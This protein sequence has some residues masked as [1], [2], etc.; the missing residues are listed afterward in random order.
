MAILAASELSVYLLILILVILCPFVSSNGLGN[1]SGLPFPFPT[2]SVPPSSL[3]EFPATGFPFPLPSDIQPSESGSFFPDESWNPAD[4]SIPSDFIDFLEGITLS[5]YDEE[6]YSCCGE[7]IPTG[8]ASMEF[9]VVLNISGLL[10][11]LKDERAVSLSSGLD[12]AL[13]SIEFW[14]EG[15]D[16]ILQALLELDMGDMKFDRDHSK[17]DD[18]GIHNLE[19][20]FADDVMDGANLPPAVGGSGWALLFDGESDIVRAHVTNFTTEEI[21]VTYWIRATEISPVHVMLEY[22]GLEAGH[23]GEFCLYS[24][25]LLDVWVMDGSVT[26]GVEENNAAFVGIPGEWMHVAV[27]YS[28]PMSHVK[29]WVNGAVVNDHDVDANDTLS[30]EGFF[31]L[32]GEMDQPGDEFEVA[33]QFA[34]MFDE[35]MVFPAVL[36]DDEV[37]DIYATSRSPDRVLPIVDFRFD[38]EGGHGNVSVDSENNVMGELIGVSVEDLRLS[39]FSNEGYRMA[40]WSISGAIEG[41]G[42]TWVPSTIP[43]A[44]RGPLVST[45]MRSRR[46]SPITLIA[47]DPENGT[48]VY[49]IDSLPSQGILYQTDDGEMPSEAITTEGTA[50]RNSNGTVLYAPG[51]TAFNG[52]PGSMTEWAMHTDI[53]P[54]IDQFRYCATD[55]GGLSSCAESF[56][57]ENHAPFANDRK[58]Y[59]GEDSDV[60][61]RIPCYDQ[62]GDRSRAVF[63][64]FPQQG[65]LYNLDQDVYVFPQEE[66]PV[67][68]AVRVYPQLSAVLYDL[69]LSEY[70]GDRITPFFPEVNTEAKHVIFAPGIE[71]AGVGYANM[72]YVCVDEFGQ[73]SNEGTLSIDVSVV[74]DAPI[75]IGQQLHMCED[76]LLTI[77]L[78]AYDPDS[79]YLQYLV[80]S[81]PAAGTM[82]SADNETISKQFSE[83]KVY[84]YVNSGVRSLSTSNVLVGIEGE[85][86]CYPLYGACPSSLPAGYGYV[87]LTFGVPVFPLGIRIFESYQPGSVTRIDFLPMKALLEAFS[88]LGIELQAL[89]D[90][91]YDLVAALDGKEVADVIAE[92]VAGDWVTVYEGRTMPEDPNQVRV[93]APEFCP[94]N[95]STAVVRLK[96]EKDPDLGLTYPYIDA[97]ELLG[98]LQM[99]SN[100][101]RDAVV[102]YRPDINDNGS[103]LA[104][105][106]VSDCISA[107]DHDGI[108]AITICPVNDAPT[109]PAFSVVHFEMRIGQRQFVVAPLRRDDVDSED[110]GLFITASPPEFLPIYD[111]T[112]TAFVTVEYVASLDDAADLPNRVHIG[113]PFNITGS[114]ANLTIP[115]DFYC[116]V[117]KYPL[118]YSAFDGELWSTEGVLEIHCDN[119][120]SVQDTCLSGT[121]YETAADACVPCPAGSYTMTSGQTSCLL[122]DLG[123]YAPEPGHSK[124]MKCN[125]TSYAEE[126]GMTACNSCPRGTAR[127]SGDIGDSVEDCDCSV[128]YYRPPSNPEGTECYECPTGAICEGSS[129][130]PY[131]EDGFWGDPDFPYEFLECQPQS[132][133]KSNFECLTGR[134]GTLC[135]HCVDG[136]FSVGGRCAVCPENSFLR[137]WMTI[138]GI[139]AVILVWCLINTVA[140]FEYDSVDLL[141]LYLQAMAIISQ[142]GLRW[143]EYLEPLLQLVSVVNFDVDFFSPQCLIPWNYGSRIAIQLSVPFLVL[144]GL[145]IRDYMRAS[146]TLRRVLRGGRAMAWH[147]AVRGNVFPSD[148]TIGTMVSV[149]DV[150]YHTLTIKSL[151]PMFCRQMPDGS[152][153]LWAGPSVICGSGVHLVLV[154]MG[155]LGILLYAIGIPVLFSYIFYFGYKHDMLAEP[156]FQKRYGFLFTRYEANYFWWH[157]MLIVRKLLLCI[158][159]VCLSDSPVLQGG[160]ALFVLLAGL[161]GQAYSRPFVQTQLDYL[162]TMLVTTL[163]VFTYCGIM[164]YEGFHKEKVVV[165]LFV[166]LTVSLL[167]TLTVISWE[168]IGVHWSRALK[169][170]KRKVDAAARE[171]EKEV[172]RPELR[173]VEGG[174][175]D[176]INVGNG[177]PSTAK[178]KRRSVWNF[179]KGRSGPE[180]D[181][182]TFRFYHVIKPRPLYKWLHM[183]SKSENSSQ[184]VQLLKLFTEVDAAV[185]SVQ[186]DAASG[187]PKGKSMIH[188]MPQGSSG[189]GPSKD[190]RKEVLSIARALHG[191]GP[192]FAEARTRVDDIDWLLTA[193]SRDRDMYTHA[194]RRAAASAGLEVSSLIRESAQP[195][196][197]YYLAH[198]SHEDRAKTRVLLE[199]IIH[200]YREGRLPSESITRLSGAGSLG[201]GMNGTLRGL[202]LTV[203]NPLHGKMEEKQIKTIQM[204]SI[205]DQASRNDDD[206][207]YVVSV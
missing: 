139:C 52:V 69:K 13:G 129:T 5:G 106:R 163:V 88:A 151:E 192:V 8:L 171:R 187:V 51:A 39:E 47:R 25:W 190:R 16:S 207:L 158:I 126:M 92:A 118:Y 96:T 195:Y 9:P 62:D 160:L 119:Y 174:N 85:P 86:D 66:L 41:W 120:V 143:H 193:D 37:Y 33:Q 58:Y 128:N 108:V 84:Q 81:P 14:L 124:C 7:D 144:V 199:S 1:H 64:G 74:D 54:A 65:A 132:H 24:E 63:T 147:N 91:T 23:E 196:L 166:V 78:L 100:I 35:V 178:R 152:S 170:L 107:G 101:V 123:N 55:P 116:H 98:R 133:C 206:A 18:W 80:S 48:L 201:K 99:S 20:A 67:L 82:Y 153:V 34:G 140:A 189:E 179:G 172:S 122:C 103:Y 95:F 104:D 45:V 154:A 205:W 90:G 146:P 184:S 70:Y 31:V 57:L 164:F 117:P 141:L 79:D 155:G 173:L 83:R 44:G 27:S 180:K 73:T 112:G 89:E 194:L 191:V 68:N 49:T 42:P 72:T 109:V 56:L 10:D 75:P 4:T 137:L 30:S 3:S 169:V 2:E 113:Y 115:H 21:T 76:S 200:V 11:Q 17:W 159:M 197:L 46:F 131:P 102:Y 71:Q 77:R 22:S 43:G 183:I 19:G 181:E 204:R 148:R 93:F 29:M 135:R 38:S 60:L 167:V 136:R 150:M 105:F 186:I 61:I 175:N 36:S 138:L 162:E 28:A 59:I 50:V 127:V 130:Q 40:D 87:T 32:G 168:L 203:Q 12:T 161:M 157:I 182:K 114:T 97:V 6:V 110:V 121:Y 202:P 177:G 142:Y 156:K 198:C 94:Q 125:M 165:L 176:S 53:N 145:L 15:Y 185:S 111:S 134:E 188:L 26:I 149:L